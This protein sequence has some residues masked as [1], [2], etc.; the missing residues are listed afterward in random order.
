[1]TALFRYRQQTDLNLIDDASDGS[2]LIIND[3][4]RHNYLI[5]SNRISRRAN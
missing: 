4:V 5:S 3:G 2:N 1:M